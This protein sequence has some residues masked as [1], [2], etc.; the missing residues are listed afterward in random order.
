LIVY[1]HLN[2]K[3][4]FDLDFRSFKFSSY[5]AYLSDKETK[6]ERNEILYLFGDLE[7]FIS[8]HNQKNSLLN[9][10]YTFE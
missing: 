4:H 8:C 6:I 5:Q 7:N 9:E 2:P 10:N 3:Y 1:V